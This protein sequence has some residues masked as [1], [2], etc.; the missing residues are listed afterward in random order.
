MKLTKKIE[1]EIK[2]LMEDY[3]N[4]Y[5]TGKIEPWSKYLVDNYRN[6]GGTE[7][8]IWDSKKEML[9]YTYEVIDQ[10]V[11]QVQLRNKTIQ[12]IPY[13]P[14]FMVHELLDMYVKVDKEWSFYGKFRLSSLIKKFGTDWKVLHQHGSFPD[15]KTQK[16]EAFAV[17]ALKAE[18]VKLQK[19][20]KKRTIELEEKNYELEVEGALGRI[21]AQAVAMKESSD[22]LD[23]VVTMRNEFIKL[24]HEAHY[25][26][27]MMWLPSTYE[28]AM[29]SG[30]GTRIG[31]V[32]ELPRHIHGDIPLLAKWEKSKKSTVVYTMDVEATIDYVD[33]MVALGD[34]QNI[35]PQAPTHDDIRHIGGLTFIMARTSHGEIGYS[36]PGVVK[37]PPKEDLD[38]LVQF[39]G[40]FDLAH[41]R[42]L[43]LQ[44]AEKQS[45]EVQ[46]E[47]ALEKVRSRSMAMH[48]SEELNEVILEVHKKFKDL[49]ISM[50]SRV[51]TVVVFD[52]SSK[53]HNQYI[54]SPDVSNMYIS[55]PYFKHPVLDDIETAKEEGLDFYSKAYS[56]KEKNSYFKTFFETSNF[57]II[58]GIAEQEQW[59][60]EKKFYTF[61]PAI[62]K[63]SSIGIADFSGIPLTETEIDIIKRFSKVFEQAYIRFLDLQKAEEQAREAQ[64][65][66]ALEKV[67]SRTMAMQKGEELQDVVVLLYKE[68]IALGVTN[69]VTCGYV[70]VNEKTNRQLTW[71]TSPGGDSLGLFHIPLTGDAVFD[72]RYAAW[73]KQQ[74]VFHQ[75]VA[76][77]KR[78]SHLEYAITTFNSKEAEEM[79]LNQFPDPT[80]FYCF[81]FSHGYLHLVAGSELTKEEESLLA[82]FT[83]IFEQTYARFL[84]LKKAEA[85]A[86]ESEIELAL[87]RVRARSMAMQKSEELKEV[88]KIVYQQL[89]HLKINLDH[90]GF[91]V[92]YTPR[93]DWHFWIA[94]EQDIPS[95]I[96]HPYF[97]SV[98]ANQFNEAKEKGAD[99]FATNLNFEEKNKFY[100]ELLSLIPGLPKASKD[101]Y[102]SCPGLAASTV[103][104]DSVG[105]YIE[106]FKGIPYTEEEN[107]ILMRFGKVFQQTYTRFLDL[108]KAEAQA[109]EAQIENALEKVRSRTMAM[110]QSDELPEAANNLFLQVQDLGIPAWSAG[111]CIWR[112][113]KKSAWS[114]MS[115]E[116]VIQKPF[117]IPNIGEGY[118]KT[119]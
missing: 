52:E 4:L 78:L 38:I 102:L 96:T 29:T 85:Q 90:S 17:D 103:L 81:N 14:Y 63:K 8:E 28:K 57:G 101:F 11:D 70:E 18:N 9:D 97:E 51:A 84:D 91:V 107:D 45:R 116:G 27:H 56:L 59:V 6:I 20:V 95:K 115:S 65:E 22:L 104:L 40:A 26:W 67:R 15:S 37:N 112:N 46:I 41:R 117:A 92:D 64:I 34:F 111:Y 2:D 48:K 110:Q 32:M 50:E 113:D 53:D 73:K 114:N 82:R 25:F 80:V 60:L 99:F 79:I 33:K 72:E 83:K 94:D 87:E 23:I 47:L 106:N 55:T 24:G 93:G 118:K 10:M 100:N 76:S 35:D 49:E 44:K 21:R 98:W 109:R 105:L 75:T 86:R 68:L 108:Q 61:S 13:D 42:F 54:A 16:G 30:D 89:T 66:T 5:L 19:A 77:K 12:I 31:F 36:L 74:I 3:W 58:E 119:I 69:F 71:V 1:K 43:D 7:E 62:Q 88:I 39:A